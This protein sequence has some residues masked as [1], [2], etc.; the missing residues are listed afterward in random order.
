MLA[1]NKHAANEVLFSERNEAMRD[2]NDRRRCRNVCN[3]V[4]TTIF[5]LKNY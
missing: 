3:D 2:R 1:R 5:V 4:V